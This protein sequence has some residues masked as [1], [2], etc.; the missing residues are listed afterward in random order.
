M[1]LMRKCGKRHRSEQIVWALIGGRDP[2]H[3]TIFEN[4][5][6]AALA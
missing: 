3:R 5:R 4:G 6:D 2:G 1:L